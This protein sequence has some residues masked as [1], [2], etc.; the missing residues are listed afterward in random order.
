VLAKP[1]DPE[2]LPSE[3]RRIWSDARGG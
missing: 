3:L 1:F 2:K